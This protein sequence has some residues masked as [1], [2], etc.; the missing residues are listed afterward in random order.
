M[1]LVTVKIHRERLN[2][3]GHLNASIYLS[4]LSLCVLALHSPLFAVAFRCRRRPPTAR[5]HAPLPFA[6]LRRGFLYRLH[7]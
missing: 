4:L 7:I 6:T 3:L 5:H 1:S 2:L